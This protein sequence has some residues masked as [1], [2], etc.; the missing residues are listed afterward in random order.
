MALHRRVVLVVRAPKP[1]GQARQ[2]GQTMG[3]VD[4]RAA[5]ARPRVDEGAWRRRARG[6]SQARGERQ[7]RVIHCSRGR[8][9]MTHSA[10]H[11]CNY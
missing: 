7:R 4:A 1:R 9:F 10:P 6:H 11:P 3:A 2:A 5:L 8:R